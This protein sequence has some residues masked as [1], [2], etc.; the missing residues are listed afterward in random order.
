M[1]HH[2]GGLLLLFVSIIAF[3]CVSCNQE[4][5]N[6]I[7]AALEQAGTNR[8]EL[9]R[10][11]EYFEKQSDKRKIAAARFLVRNMQ[12]HY[13]KTSKTLDEYYIALDSINRLT[14][15]R[16][17]VSSQ[18][19]SLY[20]ALGRFPKQVLFDK[21]DTQTIKAKEL[22]D[23]IERSFELYDNA[24]WCRDLNFND[25]CEYL[26]PYRIGQE[27][28]DM[29]WP[30]YYRSKVEERA[31]VAFRYCKTRRDTLN[32]ILQR[33][34]SNYKINIEYKSKYQYGYKPQQLFSLKKGTCTNYTTLATFMF[35]S[36]GIPTAIDFV[37][38][39]GNRSLG[40]NWNTLI[41]SHHVIDT[42]GA[43]DYSFSAA[44]KPLGQYLKSNPN[45]PS[46][47]Y[48][49]TFSRQKESLA[50]LCSGEKIPEELNSE[51]IIDVSKEYGLDNSLTI[52]VPQEYKH[53]RIVY[54]CT[55]D[56]QKWRPI[57]W[58]KLRNNKAIFN[59]L[60]NKIIYLPAIYENE[61]IVGIA[62]PVLIQED[63][64]VRELVANRC[65]KQ[66]MILYRKYSSGE[67]IRRYSRLFEGGS[68]DVSNN[69]YFNSFKTVFRFQ[70]SV[71]VNYQFVRLDKPVKCR[72]VR[73][74][75]GEGK[76]GGEVADF[77][78]FDNG[79]NLV[80]ASPI[81]TSKWEEKCPLSAS[82]DEDV[83]T[84]SKSLDSSNAWLGLDFGMEKDIS[85]IQ[86]LPHND[87]NF[88]R[89]G[90]KYQLQYW[91]KN[92]WVTVGTQIGD[93]RQY[94]DFHGCP[95]GGLYRLRNLSKGREERI[96]T[97]EKGSQVWW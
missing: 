52:T 60:G 94:L 42:V 70:D 36:V 27:K 84:Y 48:R 72:Y 20:K 79:G 7:Q 58:T 11:L 9:E 5:S 90:E 71:S 8:L 10:A 35:R 91:G 50:V 49:Y 77:K 76:Y 74:R 18:Q 57:A 78:V 28:V 17:S 30:S 25:F 61:K 88:I 56:N 3:H 81:G 64:S 14:P 68:I 12:Y 43:L 47:V 89:K 55:F 63:G 21:Y 33:M 26:L 2:L 13:T 92:S 22:I 37:P 41:L 83:L 93:A 32:A 75:A 97:Y 95:S 23:H 66:N 38:I 45:R 46:K 44:P 86:L 34:S 59:N 80:K 87:D 85:E 4:E 29:E 69:K 39:W 51:F 15:T 6:E 40:H 53:H 67:N 1:K 96:F 54:L 19:D 24:L 73:F 82:F 62:S 31:N 65:A 16:W